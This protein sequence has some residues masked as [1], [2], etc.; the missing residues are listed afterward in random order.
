MLSHDDSTRFSSIP[1]DGT[2]PISIWSWLSHTSFSVHSSSVNT[3]FLKASLFSGSSSIEVYE[4]SSTAPPL[5][6]TLLRC[7]AKVQSSGSDCSDVGVKDEKVL[8]LIPAP[9]TSN[10]YM[11]CPGLLFCV[12]AA[13][14]ASDSSLSPVAVIGMG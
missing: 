8:F 11:Y 13:C 12:A 9:N 7:T 1:C 10:Q 14:P 6:L 4:V 2:Y 3:I 5:V